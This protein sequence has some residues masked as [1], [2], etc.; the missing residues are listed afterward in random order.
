LNKYEA[1]AADVPGETGFLV[2]SL[3]VLG[4]TAGTFLVWQSAKR[5]LSRKKILTREKDKAGAAV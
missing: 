2:W 5:R 1:P 4:A 3:V